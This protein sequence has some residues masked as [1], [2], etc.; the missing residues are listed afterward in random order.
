MKRTEP[1]ASERLDVTVGAKRSLRI[2]TESLLLDPLGGTEWSTLQNSLALVDRGHKI[3]LIY[4]ADGSLR[5]QYQQAGI[6]LDG[7]VTFAFNIHRPWRGL[8]QFLPP[9]RWARAQR[10]DVLWIHRIESIYW[11]K[12]IA[13]WA[14]CPIV[15]HLRQMPSPLGLS[16]LRRSVAH[17]VAV[18]NFM[19]D[20]W[21]DAGVK[22]ERITVIHNSLPESMYPHGGLIERSETRNRLGLPPD[23]FIALCYGRMFEEKGVGTLLEAWAKLKVDADDALLVLVGSPS[24]FESPEL[25]RR[26]G[27]LDP[28]SY[29]WFPTQRDM[30]PFLHAADLVVFPTWLQEGFGRVLIEGMKTGRPVVASR[31]GAVPEVLSGPME[32][33]L[34]EPK[35]SSELSVRISSLIGWRQAEPNLESECTEWVEREFPFDLNVSAL[36]QVLCQFARKRSTRRS[37][38]K[39]LKP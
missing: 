13:T 14:R 24:P 34:F 32:R 37:R 21:I 20:A 22:P 33:F 16:I 38:S 2:L 8:S 5:E 3:F 28:K 36:E 19:R 23:A 25:A 9:A 30:L 1:S 11:A 26:L 31:I 6:A 15:C 4:G 17:Y 35:D 29:R 7:P 10:P 39:V 12:V 18:S 27:A